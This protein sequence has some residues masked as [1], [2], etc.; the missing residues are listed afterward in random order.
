MTYSKKHGEGK[1]CNVDMTSLDVAVIQGWGG[2]GLV[3]G[4]N[5]WRWPG[6]VDSVLRMVLGGWG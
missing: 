5:G 4:R 1:C 2:Q 6:L 3:I